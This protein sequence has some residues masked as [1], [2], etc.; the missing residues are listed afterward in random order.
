M[1]LR[2][3][4]ALSALSSRVR[5]CVRDA[6][7]RACAIAHKRDTDTTDRRDS[8]YNPM[9][10]LVI[11]AFALSAAIGTARTGAKTERLWPRVVGCGVS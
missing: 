6:R 5:T 10:A 8:R 11:F 4:S 7:S 1:G 2:L 9:K 3:L